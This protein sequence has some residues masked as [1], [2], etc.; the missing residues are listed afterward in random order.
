ME[1]GTFAWSNS[2]E[3]ASK[4]RLDTFLFSADWE[5]KFPTVCQR[6]VSRLLS[7]HFPTVLEGGSFIRARGVLDLRTYG[8]RMTVLWIGCVLG[9]NLIIFNVLRVLFWQTN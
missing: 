4:A 5:D 6:R 1:G 8:L 3:V 7:D 2:Q 9:G